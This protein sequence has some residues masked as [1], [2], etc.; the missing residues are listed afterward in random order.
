M[1]DIIIAK[2]IIKKLTENGYEAYIVGG[3]VRDHLLGKVNSDIDISTSALPS[4]VMDLFNKTIPTGIKHG[5]ITV[6]ID[7]FQ[8]EIT[9]FRKETNYLNNRKPENVDFVKSL[10]EDVLRR[11]FT[12]NALALTIDD[13]II[14]YVNGEADIKNKVIKTVGNAFERFNEDALRM[15]R[16]FRFVSTLGFKIDD[17]SIY[18]IKEN[19]HLINNISKERILKEFGIMI[20]GEYFHSAIKKIIQTNFHKF[21]PYFEKGIVMIDKKGFK[22]DDILEFLSFCCACGDINEILKLP[23]PN[24]LKSELKIINEMF[25]VNI[26]DFNKMLIFRNGY[27]NC[28]ITNKINIYLNNQEDKSDDIIKQYEDMPIYKQCDLKFKGD[29]IIEFYNKPPG[30]WISEVLDDICFN[31]LM[32]NLEN[33]YEKIRQYL[34]SKK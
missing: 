17:E 29:Q 1:K 32:G 21:L 13:K 31:V 18:S 8:Y 26:S 28:L 11:D 27:K 12:M 4:E 24:Y 7:K 19:A 23:I 5:T 30:G 6:I 3:Y 9:T 2:E 25:L 22:P 16:A 10:K 34:L 20:K 15:L 14:D 33:D